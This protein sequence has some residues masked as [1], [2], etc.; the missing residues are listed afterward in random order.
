MSAA[1]RPLV[2]VIIP[3]YNRVEYIDQTVQSVLDQTYPAVELIVVDDGS[4]DGSYERLQQYGSRIRL[5][6]HDGHRNRGQS[7]AI[8]LGL[9]QAKGD[10]IAILDSDDYWALNKLEVQVGF[11][12]ANP[13]IGLVYS[14][15]YAVDAGGE[16]LYDIYPASHVEHNDPNRVLLDCYILLPQNS[17]V[18]RDVFD[19][20]GRFNEQYRAAQDH[21][22]LLRIVEITAIHYLP[23]YLFYYRRHGDSI[24]SRGQ[25]VRWSNG[26]TILQQA[27][28][29][30]PYRAATLR[31]RRAVLNYRMGVCC[32]QDGEPLRAAL[33]WLKALMLDPLRAARVVLG[34]ETAN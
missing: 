24:S 26:F 15:G 27:A 4:T 31:K 22:M 13:H 21:D 6:T 33:Y 32:R 2:S 7:A 30:Y 25:R 11:L 12:Q 20:A 5:L 10:Y 18:R 17:L 8:N 14:N 23:D 34:R 19:R 1:N 28:Q 3:A 16:Y 9:S 29:R